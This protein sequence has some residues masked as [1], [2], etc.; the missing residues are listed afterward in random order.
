MLRIDAADLECYIRECCL[1]IDTPPDIA[2][3]V[4]DSLVQADL[5]GHGTH[6]V[7]RIPNYIERAQNGHLRPAGTP[8][9]NEFSES[10]LHV[11][12]NQ[13]F[14]QY[15]GRIA[16]DTMLSGIKEGVAVC[17]IRHA[18]HLGRLG[19]YAERAAAAGCIFIGCTSGTVSIVA[20]A[21]S[22]ERRF[23]TNPIAVGIPT[24]DLL[25]FPIVLDIATSQTA[26]GKVRE[27]LRTGEPLDPAWAI[28]PSGNP[29][30]DATQFMEE[31]GALRPLGGEGAGHKGTG[32]AIIVE[33]LS[34]ILGSAGV[35]SQDQRTGGNAA[36]FIVLD[37]LI[38]IDQTELEDQIASLAAYLAD[39]EP[40]PDVQIGPAATD[41][42]GCFP[43]EPEFTTLQ[44]RSKQGIPISPGIAE[45][46][47]E[48]AHNLDVEDALPTEFIDF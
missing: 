28:S 20:P 48:T 37:P 1:A 47:I 16:T 21:G 32:L 12:G 5:R 9:I 18:T 40:H 11:E 6:G 29:S 41:E 30:I 2:D 26:F 3:V 17:G 27:R 23:S 24:F 36:A 43:G 8:V 35:I 45:T 22:T 14:G 7:L 34:G 31:N 33:L 19:E 44:L 4:A 46:L 10:L 42:V 39:V 38:W 25:D 15:V 13:G